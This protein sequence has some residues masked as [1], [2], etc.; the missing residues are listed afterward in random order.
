MSGNVPFAAGESFPDLAERV[1]HA[2]RQREH[3]NHAD[4]RTEMEGMGAADIGQR[5]MK[6]IEEGQSLL[7][8]VP[9]LLEE[10]ERLKTE[11]TAAGQE[12]ERLRQ[13]NV[14]LRKEQEEI[15]GAFGTLVAEMLR[16]MNEMMQK[17][18]GTH[19]KSPLE[20]EASPAS[21]NEPARVLQSGA[22]RQ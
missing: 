20:R 13:E 9:G 19:S 11:A 18:R 14:M 21:L 22:A 6:L 12:C 17:I 1:W 16:P 4:R 5:V 3:R 2:R 7:G 15:V 10:A 8:L